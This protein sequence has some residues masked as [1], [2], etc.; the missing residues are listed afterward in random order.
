[1]TRTFAGLRFS[2]DPNLSDKTY[3]YLCAFPVKAGDAVLAPVGVRNKLQAAAVERTLAAEERDAPYD[4]RLIKEVAAPLGARKL[5]AD[6]RE[7]LEFGGV[8]YDEKHFTPFGKLL[9]A[10]TAP[11]KAEELH[12]YGVQKIFGAEADEREIFEALACA[13]GCILVIGEAGKRAFEALYAL[14]GGRNRYFYDVGLKRETV[15]LLE[16]KL[17]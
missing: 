6:G 1:M 2:G 12:A 8:R 13:R 16:E 14:L 9:W 11:E 5:M 10:K 3:W 15:A 17:Q 7:F 4:L